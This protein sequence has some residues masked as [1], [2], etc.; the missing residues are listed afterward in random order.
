[1]LRKRVRKEFPVLAMTTRME[2]LSS[3]LTIS[4][5]QHTRMCVNAR[6][7]GNDTKRQARSRSRC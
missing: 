7:A 5:N 6:A 4:D 2:I 3:V 1:M